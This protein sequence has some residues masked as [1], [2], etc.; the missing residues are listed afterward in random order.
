M[1]S[2]NSSNLTISYEI[3]AS[4]FAENI[5]LLCCNLL[6]SVDTVSEL[7]T[8]W[9]SLGSVLDQFSWFTQTNVDKI[10][11]AVKSTTYFL[12]LC[13]SCLVKDN[14][15]KVQTSLEDIINLSLGWESSQEYWK[16]KWWGYCRKKNPALNHFDLV[17][18]F[19]YTVLRQDSWVGRGST[20]A[21]FLEDILALDLFQS[22][23]Q[24]GHGIEMM[25]AAVAD[26][27]QAGRG[28]C[29]TRPLFSQESC[30]A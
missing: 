8:P 27:L 29:L 11:S 28:R 14:S 16:R 7:E 17:P 21:G 1:D 13:P 24:P 23:F 26:K 4:S 5:F 22:G 19:K 25:L 20:A 9:M 3:F 15:E 10:L 2:W 30:L 12:D 18:S 6:T